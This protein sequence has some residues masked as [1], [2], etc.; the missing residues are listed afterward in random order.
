MDDQP[1]FRNALTKLL[2]C[3]VL[4]FSLFI[5]DACCEAPS[6]NLLTE[7]TRQSVLQTLNAHYA[8]VASL[9][10]LRP[11]SLP[12]FLLHPAGTCVKGTVV[13]YHGFA[14]NA[15][16]SRLQALFLFNK[17][18]NVYAVNLAG[19]AQTSEH[20]LRS[21]LRNLHDLQ[22][23]RDALLE[24]MRIVTAARV[25][26]GETSQNNTSSTSD[27]NGLVMPLVEKV[28]ARPDPKFRKASEILSILSARGN[29]EGAL[30][31]QKYNEYFESEHMRYES[32]GLA[33][34]SEVQA[35]PGP[36]FTIGYSFGGPNSLNAIAI[37]RAVKRAVLLA[38]FFLRDNDDITTFTW[39]ASTLRLIETFGGGRE[40]TDI[41]VVAATIAFVASAT[42]DD[43]TNSA[44]VSTEMLCIMTEDDIA[45]DLEK[46]LDVCNSKLG[47][48]SFVY[49][50]W[51]GL[52]HGITPETGNPY[53]D[54]MMEQIVKFFLTGSVDEHRFM[55]RNMEP[56]K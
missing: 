25:L 32:E 55:D 35:L 26:S 43:R 30:D 15:A 48:K 13:L 7:Q 18:F 6:C 20:W 54:A 56:F 21:K 41:A 37:S 38:P 2:I 51:L 45:T 1:S 46:N 11:G 23:V 33:R 14:Y 5:S 53:S 40:P 12:L 17:G 8:Y 52:K 9:P 10:D 42:R 19:F 28:L 27:Y 16:G 39:I 36:L 34:L 4:F 44:R 31:I 24:D 50:G 22:P 49:P 3:N 47:G 29:F